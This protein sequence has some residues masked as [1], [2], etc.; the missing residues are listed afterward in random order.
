MKKLALWVGMTLISCTLFS[1][2]IVNKK[3]ILKEDKA[4]IKNDKVTI[5]SDEAQIEQ[6]AKDLA[7]IKAEKK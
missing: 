5:K 6:D 4:V 1:Q 2:E 7:K 3:T